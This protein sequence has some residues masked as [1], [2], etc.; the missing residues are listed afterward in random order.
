MG[1][2][3]IA[4]MAKNSTEVKLDPSSRKGSDWVEVILPL[5]TA[6]EANGGVKT[7]FKRNGKTCYKNEHWRDKYKRHKEQKNFVFMMLH[8]HQ[9]FLSVP[10]HIT[11]T[12]YAPKTLDRHDNLP[13]SLKYILDA[14]CAVITGDYRPGRADSSELIEVSYK[15]EISKEYGVKIFISIDKKS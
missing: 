11:L 12:R 1:S 5:F 3:N 2:T 6:S 8:Q 10:C 7:S 13:M 15:Q 4:P 9:S 14:I